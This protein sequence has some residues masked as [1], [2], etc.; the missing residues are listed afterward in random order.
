MNVL[1]PP[2][3]HEVEI[4]RLFQVLSQPVRIRILLLIGTS[5]ACVCHLQAHLGLRQA[6]I[7]QHLMALRK[8]GMVITQRDGRIIYYRLV[9]PELLDIVHQSA[10]LLNLPTGNLESQEPV[11]DCPCPHCSHSR[12]TCSGGQ[13]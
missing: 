7:S 6:V 3:H 12:Q 8:A 4:A 2:I 1:V 11:S 9:Q 13:S 10:R 5:E